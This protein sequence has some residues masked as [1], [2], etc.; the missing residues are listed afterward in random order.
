MAT[1]NVNT[2]KDIRLFPEV[3]VEIPCIVGNTG[4]IAGADGRKIIKAGTPVGS[5]TNVFENRQTVLSADG[6]NAVGVL[7]HDADV[8]AGQ[9]NVSVLIDGY[10]D[11]LK[12]DSDVVTAV[13]SAKATLTRIV[14]MKGAK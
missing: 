7:M 9:A 8:T 13:N 5:E 2:S 6:A 1:V 3:C 4:V 12:L 14:F 10:V 11:L